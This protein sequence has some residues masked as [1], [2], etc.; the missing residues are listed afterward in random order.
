MKG[1]GEQ[2]LQ[3]AIRQV[4]RPTWM[5]TRLAELRQREAP[6]TQ[7]LQFYQVQKAKKGPLNAE[8]EIFIAIQEISE[9]LAQIREERQALLLGY[10]LLQ[11]TAEHAEL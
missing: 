4:R 10:Q 1:P 11:D 7:T 2:K 8:P 9:E 5:T 3:R 6:L